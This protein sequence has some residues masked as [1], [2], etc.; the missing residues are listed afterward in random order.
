MV[1]NGLQKNVHGAGFLVYLVET[2]DTQQLR[3]FTL[4]V[5]AVAAQRFSSGEP[6]ASAMC[7]SRRQGNRVTAHGCSPL[8]ISGPARN[9]VVL[10]QQ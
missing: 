6:L 4:A 8:V 7:K 10:C 5:V 9:Q 1:T 2:T 3:A